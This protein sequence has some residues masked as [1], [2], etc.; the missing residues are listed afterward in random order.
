MAGNG[1][2]LGRKVNHDPRSFGFPAPQP[3]THR[4]VRH[5]H[6]GGVLNQGNVG[7]CVL[8]S[9]AH[10]LNTKPNHKARTRLWKQ[11]D[12]LGWYAE[13]TAIDPFPGTYPGQDTGTDAN[14]AAKVFR[15][16]G[17]ITSWEHAFGLDHVLAALQD[18]PVWLGITWD[19][20]MFEPDAKGYL[21]P[22]GREAGGH[23]TLI[24]GDDAKD[25]VLCL[26]N[27]G[28]WGP[29]HGYYKLSYADLG[30]KLKDNGDA[31]VLT[32]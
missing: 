17:L 21:H 29:L 23:E 30:A 3:G 6:W 8:T 20:S 15:S 10:N 18:K 4:P 16:H 25:T 22:D 7:S 14:S 12:A 19:E 31:V 26:N 1:Y 2:A 9:G 11:T 27:W 13:A 28:D 24:V 32:V 5:R